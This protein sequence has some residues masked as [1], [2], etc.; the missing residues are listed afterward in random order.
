MKSKLSIFVVTILVLLTL[1]STALAT[2]YK[3]DFKADN[4]A[5]WTPFTVKFTASS[6]VT[7]KN[8]DS[9]NWMFTPYNLR[10]GDKNGVTRITTTSKTLTYTFNHQCKYNIGVTINDKN[11]Q[12]LTTSDTK[13]S[14]IT[15]YENSYTTQ[16]LNPANPRII[17]FTYTGD[18]NPTSFKWVFGDG[19]TSTQKNTVTH[20]YKQAGSGLYHQFTTSLKVTNTVG[21]ST[22]SQSVTVK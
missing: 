18:G 21:S 11:N 2:T 8:I 5:G 10:K 7:G 20:T 17:T 9:Y 6:N 14:Y 19:T 12:A 4:T 16:A 1:S 13:W 15:V 3:C 22:V